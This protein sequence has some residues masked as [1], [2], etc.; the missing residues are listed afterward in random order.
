M[1]I[2]MGKKYTSNGDSVRILCTDRPND[3]GYTVVGLFENG[4]IGYFTEDGESTTTD[5]RN[6][7]EVWEPQ[8]G[9]WCLFTDSSFN[10]AMLMQFLVCTIYGRF[11]AMGSY[12][13]FDHCYKFD[14][15]LPEHLKGE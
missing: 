1:K 11:H 6:L 13:S 5:R 10:G 8:R 12:R 9:E 4:M 15:I 3:N 2:E 7:V 14:G